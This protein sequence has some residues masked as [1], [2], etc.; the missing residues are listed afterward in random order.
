MDIK[1]V[2]FKFCFRVHKT[3]NK[4]TNMLQTSTRK[5]KWK[6]LLTSIASLIYKN[7]KKRRFSKDKVKL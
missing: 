4:N 7:N 1:R 6:S 5:L 3:E 2:I